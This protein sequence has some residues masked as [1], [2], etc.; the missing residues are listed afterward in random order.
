MRVSHLRERSP[1]L[2]IRQRVFIKTIEKLME[3]RW[4]LKKNNQYN[5]LYI[6]RPSEV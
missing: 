4:L 1:I 2:T 5:L 6:C 3:K